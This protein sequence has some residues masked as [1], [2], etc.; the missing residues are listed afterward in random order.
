MGERLKGAVAVPADPSASTA[1]QARTTGSSVASTPA[2][3][4]PKT[5]AVQAVASS[6]PAA[7][8]QVEPEKA[9]IREPHDDERA[10]SVQFRQDVHPRAGRNARVRRLWSEVGAGD[11]KAEVELAQLYLKGDGVT[12]N[13]EQ[14]RVLL[15]AAAK[16]GNAEALQEY[17]KLNFA[18]CD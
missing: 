5:G 16:K 13:C 2:A 11:S 6:D 15:K 17:R 12:R 14:A 9:V 10:A 18:A 4:D 7:V 8:A 3:S 1:R